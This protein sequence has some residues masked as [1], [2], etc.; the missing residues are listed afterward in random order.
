MTRYK[1]GDLVLVRFPF[2]DFSTL[3]K[4]PAQNF[5]DPLGIRMFLKSRVS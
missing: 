3:K 5:Y 2:T 1:P 4:R